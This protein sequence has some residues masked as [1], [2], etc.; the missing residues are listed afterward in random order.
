MQ[1]RS[2]SP[3]SCSGQIRRRPLTAVQHDLLNTNQNGGGQ[4][5]IAYEVEIPTRVDPGKWSAALEALHSRH[6]ILRSGIARDGDSWSFFVD[7][8]ALVHF[9]TLTRQEFKPSDLLARPID[10][11][12]GSLFRNY[13]APTDNGSRAVLIAPHVVADGYTA[14]LYFRDLITSYFDPARPIECSSNFYDW[15]DPLLSRLN[16]DQATKYWRGQLDDVLAL[17]PQGD[18]RPSAL[19]QTLVLSRE[20]SQSIRSFAQRAGVSP[21]SVF[22]ASLALLI[23]RLFV[24]SSGSILVELQNMRRAGW[25]DML[26]CAFSLA[27]IVVR[28]EALTKWSD[29]ET[30]QNL[31]LA[32]VNGARRPISQSKLI[33]LIPS[34]QRG[35]F[36]FFNYQEFTNVSD[37]S[38]LYNIKPYDRYADSE[39]HFVVAEIGERFRL[40]LHAPKWG[41]ADRALLER[42]RVLC[43]AAGQRESALKYTSLILPGEDALFEKTQPPRTALPT[44]LSVPELI[45]EQADSHPAAVAVEMDGVGLSYRELLSVADHF[46]AQLH[47]EGV[48]KDSVVGVSIDRSLELPVVLLAVLRSGGA[49]LP[50]DPDYPA[51]RNALALEQS[52]CGILVT[53]AAA[54]EKLQPTRDDLSTWPDKVLFVDDLLQKPPG[55]ERLY[56]ATPVDPKSAAYVIFTS[57]STGRPKGAVIEHHALAN[58]L[59][60]MKEHYGLERTDRILQ[61]TPAGFDVSVWEFFLPLI[62]GGTLVMAPPAAHRDASAVLELVKTYRI[63]MLHFVPSMFERFLERVTSSRDLETVRWIICS[64]EALS[65]GVLSRFNAVCGDTRLANLYGPTEATIDVSYWDAENR[66]DRKVPIGQAVWNTRLFVAD[67]YL[68]MLPRGWTGELLLAG[69]QLAREYLRDPEQTADRFVSLPTTRERVYR[70]GDNACVLADGLIDFRGRRDSQV[71]IGGVRIELGEIE[72]ALQGHSGITACRVIQRRGGE[73]GPLLFAY[74]VAKKS[75]SSRELRTYLSARIP[76]A[77]VPQAF[78][79]LQE[80]PVTANGKLDRGALPDIQTAPIRG[81]SYAPPRDDFEAII[82]SAIAASLPGVTVGRMD[83]LFALGLSSVLALGLARNL[84]HST[85]R[86]VAP[87]VVLSNP[88]VAELS[89]ALRE[90]NQGHRSVT[91]PPPG[92]LRLPAEIAPNAPGGIDRRSATLL[93]GAT[94]FL[95]AQLLAALLRETDGPIYCLVRANTP[96][97]AA[98]RLTSA[99]RFQGLDRIHANG[100]VKAFPCDIGHERLGLS[101][102]VWDQ[103]AREVSSIYHAAARVNAALPYRQLRVPNVVGTQE[104][105]RLAAAREPMALH[106]ISTLSVLTDCEG[107]SGR[108]GEESTP[109]LSKLLSAY[110]VSKA[111]GEQLIHQAAERGL[112]CTI[113]RPGR[114]GGSESIGAVNPVDFFWLVIRASAILRCVP[115]DASVVELLPVDLC[116]DAIVD[117]GRRVTG[118][119]RVP[120][121][122]LF[123]SRMISWGEVVEAVRVTGLVSDA[124]PFVEW[125]ARLVQEASVRQSLRPLAS[126]LVDAENL[127]FCPPFVQIDIT[128]TVASLSKKT[129]LAGVDAGVDYLVKQIN[130]LEASGY[131]ET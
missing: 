94:G 34:H 19:T 111:A 53:T 67:R 102:P 75:V 13:L 48:E 23:D 123:P 2:G 129:L 41:H 29:V 87:T 95:G 70:T 99:L 10:Q 9:E 49:Y 44:A 4:Y 126:M 16:S 28:P 130:F 116:S 21:A 45:A 119:G 39:V 43:L 18:A 14:H 65:I 110:S 33:D 72:F 66:D 90:E 22:R 85:G 71:K 83:D 114:L 42:Y 51:R 91:I 61:K 8:A 112:K 5:N 27:P 31:Q 30:V 109:E 97:E 104:I 12:C 127:E 86:H 25:A 56:S 84:E 131:L 78:V 47:E 92:D 125:R 115:N 32:A 7:P 68:G 54:Y 64:G 101:E 79:E 98:D 118:E 82:V 106:F 46:A 121:Y 63:T 17:F 69:S 93:T 35:L 6:E 77:A 74:Y 55:K 117:L 76:G 37:G 59:L 100:R 108:L 88:S 11:S 26:G 40:E 103:L 113:H 20:E 58:R 81:P 15:D 50:L 128:A 124:V 120:T 57:G 3:H 105:I 107:V 80:I 73:N 89:K 24:P 122:H 1:E 60:W 38:H 52:Q 96:A 36:F 62:S